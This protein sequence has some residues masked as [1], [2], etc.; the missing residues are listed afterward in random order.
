VGH[1]AQDLAFD[2]QR[3]D[4]VAAVVADHVADDRDLAGVGVDVEDADV[5]ARGVGRLRRRERACVPPTLNPSGS[6]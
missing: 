6:L 5:G 2:D 1:P 3:V 4:Y